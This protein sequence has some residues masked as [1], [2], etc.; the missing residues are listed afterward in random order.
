MTFYKYFVAHHLASPML[1]F[2]NVG[3]YLYCYFT[4]SGCDPLIGIKLNSAFKSLDYITWTSYHSNVVLMFQITI[5]IFQITIVIFGVLWPTK[6]KSG[7][8]FLCTCTSELTERLPNKHEAYTQ[9]NAVSMLVHRLRRWPN[10]ETV[11]GECLVFA[12]F[13]T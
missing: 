1:Y 3:L 6:K 5:C 11:L 12:G 13:T 10:I 7:I 2:C 4:T 9:P 8:N